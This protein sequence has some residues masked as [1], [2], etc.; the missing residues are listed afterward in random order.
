M[1]PDLTTGSIVVRVEFHSAVTGDV[2]EI[3]RMYL[4]HTGGGHYDAA[5]MHGGD[6][7]ALDKGRRQRNAIVPD[8]P[9][10]THV[11]YLVARALIALRYG[12]VAK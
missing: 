9:R 10:V 6:T 3:A 8:Y 11:W 4:A 5:T 12:R 1:S 7:A 2:S